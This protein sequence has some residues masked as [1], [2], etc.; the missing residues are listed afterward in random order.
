M[1]NMMKDILQYAPY[2]LFLAAVFALLA[3]GAI[4]TFIIF[5]RNDKRYGEEKA[6]APKI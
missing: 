1:I 4:Y 6:D 3:G 2:A 5:R